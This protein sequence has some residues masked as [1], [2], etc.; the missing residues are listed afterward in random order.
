MSS[1]SPGRNRYLL[2]LAALLAASLAL[3]LWLRMG[4][5]PPASARQTLAEQRAQTRPYTGPDHSVAVLP[6]RPEGRSGETSPPAFAFAHDLQQALAA[7]A[8]LQVIAPT[9]AL[10]FRDIPAQRSRIA[11][12][13]RSAWL[14]GGE[15]RLEDGRLRLTIELQRAGSGGTADTWEMEMPFDDPPGRVREVAAEI[16]ERLPLEVGPAPARPAPVADSAW[17]RYAEGI[18]HASAAGEPDL[19]R[20]SEAFEAATALDAAFVAAGLQQA[21]L[22]LHPGWPPE[23]RADR[24]EGARRIIAELLGRDPQDGHALALLAWIRHDVDWDWPGALELGA[25][26]AR[27]APGSAA[28]LR[29]AGLAALTMGDH[30]RAVGWLFDAAERDPL[31]LGGRL[32]LGLAQEYARDDEAALLTLKQVAMLNPDVPGIHAHRAR[33]KVLEGKPGV[34]MEEAGREADPFWSAYATAL[35]LQGLGRQDEAALALESLA[36]DQ[37]H[38]AAFQVAELLAQQG[39]VDE[40]FDWLER[41]VRQ[42]DGGLS[43]LLGNRLLEPL[44]EDERWARLL[45]RLE[46]PLDSA[47]TPTENG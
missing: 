23:G 39:R 1:R 27:A 28:V 30:E 10:F 32:Q 18:Y 8:G 2:P 24:I 38:K 44:A 31:N 20:A 37:G 11:A 14:I 40:A 26:A 15:W 6:F 19:P 21:E 16:V 17:L 46:L 4:E 41:A 42:R 43:A 7:R 9:S 36:A 45:R 5:G 33:L 3:T 29:L 12:R 47:V 34:A 25:A 13:L 22:L 35:A